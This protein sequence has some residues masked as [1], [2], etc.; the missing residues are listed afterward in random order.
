LYEKVGDEVSRTKLLP[1]LFVPMTGIAK[2][3]RTR[4]PA[5]LVNG[6]FQDST[7]G[8]PAGWFY[9]RQAALDKSA[10]PHDKPC[11][12]FPN[13]DPGADGAGAGRP[14]P[15]DGPAEHCR[16]PSHSD[17][18]LRPVAPVRHFGSDGLLDAGFVGEVLHVADQLPVFD[19]LDRLAWSQLGQRAEAFHF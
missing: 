2:G 9:L 7:D 10:G 3:D 1:T 14:S 5:G 4:S 16:R 13:S 17:C 8:V 19:M 6:S 18:A 12:N 11:L 15:R